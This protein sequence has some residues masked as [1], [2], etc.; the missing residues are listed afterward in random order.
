MYQV[1]KVN[2]T[3]QMNKPKEYMRI[4]RDIYNLIEKKARVMGLSSNTTELEV[5]YILGQQSILKII[6]D[7][8]LVE[9]ASVQSNP[10]R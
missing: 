9:N 7:D 2:Q 3:I 1:W 5:A 8:I 6:R 10:Y 4:D